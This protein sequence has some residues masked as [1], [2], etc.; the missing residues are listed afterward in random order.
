[1][2][3][4]KEAAIALAEPDTA[5]APNLDKTESMTSGKGKLRACKKH[6]PSRGGPRQG[7]RAEGV[8]TH[9]STSCG[10]HLESLSGVPVAAEQT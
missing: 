9:W 4:R 1:M 6:E 3:V 7:A 5:E 8:G 10:R 2:A